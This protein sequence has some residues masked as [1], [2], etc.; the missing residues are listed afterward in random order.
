PRKMTLKNPPQNNQ[1][2][3]MIDLNQ[4]QTTPPTR[5]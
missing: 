2:V 4:P 1:I 3:P 5:N